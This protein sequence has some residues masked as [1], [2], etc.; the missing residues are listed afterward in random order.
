M[1]TLQMEIAAFLMAAFVVGF[2]VVWVL[3]GIK[4]GS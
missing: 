4:K 2:G 1:N 3:T